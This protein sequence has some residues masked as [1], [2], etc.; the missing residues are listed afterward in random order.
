MNTL[1]ASLQKLG[2]PHRLNSHDRLFS[3]GETPKYLFYLI[4]GGIKLTRCSEGGGECT[5]QF[6]QQGFLAEASLFIDHYHCDAIA[7][8][9]SEVLACPID[10]VMR[11]LDVPEFRNTWIQLLSA[12]VRRLRSQVERLSLKTAK[13][14]VIHYILTEGQ[15]RAIQLEVSKKRWAVELG[16]TH[17]ALYRTLRDMVEDK[18]LVIEGKTYRLLSTC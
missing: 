11:E 1:P 3:A 15:N 18:S 12:E 2:K 7:T 8:E 16:L 6:I 13:E 10:L 5:L 17:E 14:R 9:T 4:K